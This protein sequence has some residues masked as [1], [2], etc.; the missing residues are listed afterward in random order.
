M[1]FQVGHN[2]PNRGGSGLALGEIRPKI[3]AIDV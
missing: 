2:V 3:T 1:S